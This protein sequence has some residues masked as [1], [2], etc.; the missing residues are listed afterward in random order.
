MCIHIARWQR[1]AQRIPDPELRRLA[2]AALAKR[3]NIEGAAAFAAFAPARN[4]RG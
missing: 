1:L 3:G 4:G 2:L